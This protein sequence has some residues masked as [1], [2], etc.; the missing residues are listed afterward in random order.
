MKLFTLDIKQSKSNPIYMQLYNYIKL[1]MELGHISP[2][3]KLPSR[4]ALASH[5]NISKNTIDTAY[6]MLL[7][8]GYIMSLPKSGYY[9]SSKLPSKDEEDAPMYSEYKHNFSIH[10]LDTSHAPYKKWNRAAKQ[11]QFDDVNL[12]KL[13]ERLGN[14]ELRK[15]ITKFIKETQNITCSPKNIIIGAGDEYLLIYLNKMLELIHNG[16]NIYG[17][18]NP[19]YLNSYILLKSNKDNIRFIDTSLDGLDINKLNES[20]INTFYSMPSHHIPTGYIMNQQQKQQLLDWAYSAEDKYIIEDSYDSFYQYSEKK[21]KSLFSLDTKDRVIYM[22]SFAR[23][24]SPSIRISFVILPDSLLTIWNNMHNF[25]RCLASRFDQAIILEFMARGYLHE[26]V[27]FTRNI[28]I[29]KRDFLINRLKSSSIGHNI[30][31]INPNAGT[32]FLIKYKSNLSEKELTAKAKDFG[33][34]IQ[35]LSVYYVGNNT[36]N[37]N[38]LVAGFGGLNE[39]EIIDAVRL[40]ERAWQ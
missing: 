34:K 23:I 28:Y 4:R 36:K 8:E 18:E 29:H 2:Y 6:Q 27:N 38:L 21:H 12:F 32:H 33:I 19:C 39:L 31:I 26:Q 5:L 15:A 11:I 30:D 9:A 17:F 25:Y 10:N 7:S 1:E 40:L 35:G 37:E 14:F 20:D 16:N 22:C 3:E 24:L 13:S